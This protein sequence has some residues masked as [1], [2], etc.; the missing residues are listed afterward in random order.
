MYGA[1][2]DESFQLDEVTEAYD[3]S[4]NHLAKVV[5][6]LS[7]LGYLSTRRGRGGGIQLALPPEGIRIGKVVRETEDQPAIVECFDA[8]TNTCKLNGMCRLKGALTEAMNEF[9]KALDKQTLADL[10]A[11]PQRQKMSKVLLASH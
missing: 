9:Y 8:A 4:R 5:H 3:I 11:G 10:I 2:K 7:K 6:R 1:L